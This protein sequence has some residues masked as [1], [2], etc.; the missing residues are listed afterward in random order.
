MFTSKMP[1]DPIPKITEARLAELAARIK[2]VVHVGSR[3]F[4]IAP[5]DLHCEA[6][7]VAP[8][9]TKRALLTEIASI[10]TLHAFSHPLL[11]KP[12]VAEVL[13]QIPETLLSET[14]AFETIGP[15]D[16]DAI[17]Q[18]IANSVPTGYH[19][20]TTK[21]YRRRIVRALPL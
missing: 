10:R 11:F 17:N 3:L 13:A 8:R 7:T 6:F 12:C 19:A 9:T 16:A 5:P 4:Y 20:A 21:L 18:G 15:A 1:T 2:P 14:E